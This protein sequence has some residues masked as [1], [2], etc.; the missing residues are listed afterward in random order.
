MKVLAVSFAFP[1]LVAPRAIQVA[2][3]LRHLDAEVALVCASDDSGMNDP[4][5]EAGAEARLANCRRV[6][7]RRSRTRRR[8]DAV[9]AILR[10]PLWN[11]LPDMYRS[12][13]APAV[14]AAEEIIRSGFRPD[15]LVTFG[16]PMSDHLVGREL[17]AR[18][19]MPWVAHFSDPW[20]GNPYHAYGPLGSLV[21]RRLEHAIYRSAD[22][23]L[24]PTAELRDYMLRGG[25]PA[26]HQRSGILPHSFG[27]GSPVAR[28]IPHGTPIT[29]RHIGTL[30]GSRTVGPIVGALRRLLDAEPNRL[31]CTRFEFVGI[32][33]PGS[34]SGAGMDGLPDGLVVTRPR[35]SY[36]ESLALMAESD[37]L[38][39]MDG[40]WSGPGIFFPAKLADYIGSGRPVFGIAQPGAAA[41]I[42]RGTGGAVAP[43]DAPGDIAGGLGPF[44]DRLRAL[45]RE[46]ALPGPAESRDAY[47][48]PNVAAGFLRELD[49][50]ARCEPGLAPDLGR[51]IPAALS[52]IIL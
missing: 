6:P 40:A 19:R 31:A 35:V 7:F 5:I 30:Y 38:L 48:A 15:V 3:L 44:L 17:A 43:V 24:F 4:S 12:W 16:N 18:H 32:S 50:V 23:L 10:V 9:A 34:F 1:P 41:R 37:G 46:P 2:R 14:A 26:W 52:S 42:V 36:R 45:R 21:N 8:V 28:P 20:T 25:P 13:V 27:P 29:I 22:R 11:R 49:A 51:R 39:L 33:D 47:A